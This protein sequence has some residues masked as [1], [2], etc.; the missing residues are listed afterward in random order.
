MTEQNQ[1]I[2]EAIRK[3]LAEGNLP[4]DEVRSRLAQFVDGNKA[5]PTKP[6]QPDVHKSAVLLLLWERNE[7]L[8]VVFTLRSAK[9][10]QHSGQISFPG[11]GKENAETPEQTAL[12]ETYEEIGIINEHI[13]LLGRLTPIYVL[14]SDNYI[15]PIVGVAKT[16]L[17]FRVNRAEVEEVFTKPLDFFT[18]NNI[19]ER[20]WEIAGKMVDVPY[21]NVHPSVPLWGATAM[22]LAEF[23]EIYQQSI[24]I[25]YNIH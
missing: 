13:D 7:K 18:F 4:G 16:Y 25:S 23:V 1:N 11:G 6:V 5:R 14:P 15:Y 12:R 20:K 17:D 3:R 24:D 9:L 10:L 2:V 21:W 19:L 8:Q 22:I